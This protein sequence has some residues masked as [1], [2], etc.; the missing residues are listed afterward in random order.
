[1]SYSHY[2]VETYK[3][4]VPT[5]WMISIP[6]EMERVCL[7]DF[8][9]MGLY[10]D[11]FQYGMRLPFNPFIKDIFDYFYIAPSQITP[12]S[13][14]ILRAFEAICFHLETRPTARAFHFY[15][16]IKRGNMD[17]AYFSKRP[18]YD[19]FRMMGSLTESIPDWKEYFWKVAIN[20]METR[21]NFQSS[22]VKL[23][24]KG[25]LQFKHPRLYDKTTVSKIKKF[26]PESIAKHGVEYDEFNAEE[27]VKRYLNE[28]PIFKLLIILIYSEGSSSDI[29]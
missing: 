6:T 21:Y 17:W 20:P 28:K 12:N 18:E 25:E 19:N 10:L 7:Y 29:P 27:I 3:V 9:K 2:I 15:F 14:R 13:W 16:C 26:V 24:H 1:M 4:K 23:I 5:G 11:A 8:N 22:W